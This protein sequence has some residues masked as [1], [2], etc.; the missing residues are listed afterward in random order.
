MLMSYED[1]NVITLINNEKGMANDENFAN[2]FYKSERSFNHNLIA[3]LKFLIAINHDRPSSINTVKIWHHGQMP[4]EPKNVKMLTACMSFC[5]KRV[6]N[7][8]HLHGHMPGGAFST[9]QLQCR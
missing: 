6:Q 8:H 5:T 7:V 4:L 1:K 9:G 2:N 3:R